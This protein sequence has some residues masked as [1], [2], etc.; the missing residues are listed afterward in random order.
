MFNL[1]KLDLFTK[2]HFSEKYARYFYEY[3]LLFSITLTIITRLNQHN[4]N[5][6]DK[7]KIEHKITLFFF[8]T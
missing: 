8:N 4:K 2:Y 1:S 5:Q 7:N 6:H 3:F